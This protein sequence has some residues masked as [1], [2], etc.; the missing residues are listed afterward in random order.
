MHL[1]HCKGGGV[2]R[3]Q[4][5]RV[6][7]TNFMLYS[8]EGGEARVGAHQRLDRPRFRARAQE[9]GFRQGRGPRGH[10]VS[11]PPG[12]FPGDTAY[13]VTTA[14]EALFQAPPLSA[15]F[16]CQLGSMMFRRSKEL[17]L[18]TCTV[19]GSTPLSFSLEVNT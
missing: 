9:E 13:C 15:S 14:P 5:L 4:R 8:G 6:T 12:P 16:L 19:G 11:A 1:R 18:R 10:R 17:K 3:R 7:V 2:R